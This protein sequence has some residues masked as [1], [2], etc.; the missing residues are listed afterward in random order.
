MANRILQQLNNQLNLAPD[1]RQFY[2]KAHIAPNRQTFVNLTAQQCRIFS[3]IDHFFRVS[4]YEL[5]GSTDA[6]KK[7][8]LEIFKQY[9]RAANVGCFPVSFHIANYKGNIQ[10]LYG[11][12][13]GKSDD[14]CGMLAENVP[15]V[16]TDRCASLYEAIPALSELQSYS[17][18][19]VGAGS[20]IV[21]DLDMILN[22]LS[23][24]DFMCSIVSRPCQ[25]FELQEELGQINSYLD[26]YQQLSQYQNSYGT[27][28]QRNIA[29][30]NHAVL[31]LINILENT[32]MQISHSSGIC[33]TY[34]SIC[35][36]DATSYSRVYST[37]SSSL[38]SA[39][40]D[41]SLQGE[42]VSLITTNKKL[43]STDAWHVP[44]AF[45]GAH[46]FGGLF[47]NSFNNLCHSDTVA[48][49]FAL[50][51]RPHRGVFVRNQGASRESEYTAF[52][53]Y[54][55]TISEESS[56][57]LGTVAGT[58][59]EFLLH[60]PT[61]RQH[62]F[63]SGFTQ[64]GKTTTTLRILCEAAKANVPFVVLESAKKQYCE[65]LAM[66]SFSGKLSIYSG[67]YDTKLLRINPFQPEFGTI[68]DNHIQS[69]IELLVAMFDEQAPLPQILSLLVHK[70]YERM[71]WMPKDRVRNVEQRKFPT[72]STMLE[73]IDEVID[74]IG[75]SLEIANNMKGVIR[76]RL[77]SVIQGAMGDILNSDFNTSIKEMF[78]NSAIVELDDFSESNKTFVA[79]LLALKTYEYSRSQDYGN[80][81]RRLLVIEE[82]HNIVPNVDSYA[83][84]A[85]IA[86]CSK[87]F[88]SL[89]AEV[90]AY[91][92]GLIIIDQRPSAVSPA[93]IANTGTKI[94]HNLQA[95][96]D[97]E[98]ISASM[99][100]TDTEKSII[101]D[102]CVGQA[103][104]KT[105]NT[106]EK[107]RISVSKVLD[108][109]KPINWADLFLSPSER[110]C[111]NYAASLAEISLMAA[112]TSVT[113]LSQCIAFA[114]IING[115]N[116]S[117]AEKMK[118]AGSLLN[119]LRLSVHEKRHLL[120]ELYE[121]LG[122]VL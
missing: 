13:S 5:F 15:S 53:R 31:D 35:A 8:I 21:V 75:Y 37:L 49:L 46:N 108:G 101:S 61:L 67:G 43:F 30:N 22:T 115:R 38:F 113:G 45:L 62:T 34:I 92:T 83:S 36:C 23:R 44:C 69:L 114:E 19:I 82:A 25:K 86:L 14:L 91:G 89:L 51:S 97:K 79:G 121:T 81:T 84:N 110:K 2:S 54:A 47:S 3:E 106:S 72:F 107:C 117:L 41:D 50:P 6:N 68:L 116:F 66:E 70:A 16:V 17:G 58:G 27:N 119:A 99:S 112:N 20:N 52:S 120:F 111:S 76:G 10:L 1:L 57:S 96:E 85:N 7:L 29:Q 93:V 77:T 32:K 59:D 48:A 88:S 105:A 98:T 18:F 12:P 65:L 24:T 26:T 74:G 9:I 94:I 64:C 100:L 95:G 103:I 122:G 73:L 56:F 102:L 87:H 118:Y 11:A 63:I 109:E 39:T 60:I 104:V 33:E 78:E 40:T 90:A 71:G 55:P 28:A 42:T 4:E 80:D